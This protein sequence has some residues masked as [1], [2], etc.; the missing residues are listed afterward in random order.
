[1]GYHTSFV[2]CLIRTKGENKGSKRKIEVTCTVPC[3]RPQM[4]K[5]FTELVTRT[6]MLAEIIDFVKQVSNVTSSVISINKTSVREIVSI[7][8]EVA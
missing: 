2:L 5:E 3:C 6:L 8:T 4:W 1:M 7:A